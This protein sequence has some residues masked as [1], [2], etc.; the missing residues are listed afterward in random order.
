MKYTTNLEEIENAVNVC[1]RCNRCHYSEWPKNEEICPIYAYDQTFTYSAGGLMY[2][3][4]ALLRNLTAY[5]KEL[6]EL[7][8]TCSAC[9]G[10][11]DLCVILRSVNPD[12][13]LSDIIRLMKYEMVKRDLIPD[14]VKGT[15]QVIKEKADIP[16]NGN[17]NDLR[18]PEKIKSDQADT[19]LYA[20]C[21]HTGNQRDI[22]QKA[23][24]VLEKMGK[25]MDLFTDGGCCGST[26]FDHGFWGELPGLVDAKMEKMKGYQDKTFLFI[27]PHCQEFI[28]NRYEKIASNYEPT[29][30]QH[31]SEI[32]A[33]ALRDGKLKTKE[34]G[35][36]KVTY[37]DPCMLGRGL[38]IFDSPREVLSFFEDVEFVEM[39]RNRENAFCCGAKAVGKYFSNCP[40]GT[41]EER[42][43]EFKDTGAELLITACPYC[44]GIFQ[45]VLGM[46][47][48]RV[49]D[50]IEF[51]DERTE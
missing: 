17:G 6:S 5:T 1:L 40:E 8:Y 16:N 44:R 27:N 18:I 14:R 36:I 45:K 49:K 12:M 10:C 48:D 25:P 29:K 2:L 26:L 51:V 42:I 33:G 4:K 11:D 20:E 37:H 28:S 21:I 39:K 23:L 35:K 30:S 34:N 3:A 7:I 15:Y 24:S 19:V 22:Y 9:R 41:A 38:G 43:N 50:L 46:E 13:P 47:K 31:I 32:M